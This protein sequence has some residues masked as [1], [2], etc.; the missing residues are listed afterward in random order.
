MVATPAEIPVITPV[1][2]PTTAIAGFP[3]L[4]MP[5]A[6]VS[7]KV[8]VPPTHKFIVPV[9]APAWAKEAIENNNVIKV[10]VMCRIV[11]LFKVIKGNRMLSIYCFTHLIYKA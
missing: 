3:L 5:H 11:F 7:D 1:A 9:I 10:R 4:Q 2:E 8:V 6:G